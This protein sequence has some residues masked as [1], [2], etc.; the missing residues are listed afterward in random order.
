MAISSISKEPSLSVR[1]RG[2]EL[3]RLDLRRHWQND[4]PKRSG[5]HARPLS[6]GRNVIDLRP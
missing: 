2:F 5:E 3:D 4:L 1:T 6:A